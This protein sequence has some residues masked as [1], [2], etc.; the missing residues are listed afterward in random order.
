MKRGLQKDTQ[1]VW[2]L[3]H[4]F[5]KKN[6]IPFLHKMLIAKVFQTFCGWFRVSL[7]FL[8]LFDFSNNSVWYLTLLWMH[9]LLVNSN[10]SEGPVYASFNLGQCLNVALLDLVAVV[11]SAL[12]TSCN[13]Q[14]SSNIQRRQIRLKKCKLLFIK[15]YYFFDFLKASWT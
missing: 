9:A 5:P 7:S 1:K 10:I 6:S 3:G 12:L 4:F 14:T 8:Y 2:T 13:I 11:V 15:F